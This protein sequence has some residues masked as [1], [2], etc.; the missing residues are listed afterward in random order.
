MLFGEKGI[1]STLVGSCGRVSL[2][3]LSGYP[4]ISGLS[5]L[6]ESPA[7]MDQLSRFRFEPG[8]NYEQKNGVSF[9]GVQESNAWF[10]QDL[11]RRSPIE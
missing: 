5:P 4:I 1:S 3:M 11:R 6:D 7:V 10:W 9:L 2:N 8:L